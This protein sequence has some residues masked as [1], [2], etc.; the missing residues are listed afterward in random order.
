MWRFDIADHKDV[1]S[2]AIAF[3]VSRFHV[4]S[5]LQSRKHA[6]PDKKSPP[7]TSWHLARCVCWANSMGGVGR[8]AAPSHE[9]R[10]DLSRLQRAKRVRRCI[11]ARKIAVAVQAAAYARRSA[12]LG[13]TLG[14]Y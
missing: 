9:V 7:E 5:P 10:H 14:T 6:V 12:V 4:P 8:I 3:V 1:A 2:A 13:E 11:T